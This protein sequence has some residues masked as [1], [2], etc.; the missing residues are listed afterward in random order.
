MKQKYRA[1]FWL[2][3]S[4]LGAM[5]SAP[6]WATTVINGSLFDLSYDETQ[7]FGG[8][9]FGLSGNVVSYTADFPLAAMG[10]MSVNDFG[11]GFDILPH[12][13]VALQSV[14]MNV[15][16]GYDNLYDSTILE[17]VGSLTVNGN[18]SNVFPFLFSSFTSGS[19]STSATVNAATTGNAI[20]FFSNG[21]SAF[22]SGFGDAS[23]SIDSIQ[24]NV[25][26]A[27]VPLPAA[28][29]LFSSGLIGLIGMA[30]RSRSAAPALIV[31]A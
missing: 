15:S 16:G 28:A 5:A 3:L 26:V 23:V 10:T 8:G 1:L 7:F 31:S 22:S 21:L 9:G 6:A 20:V 30:R 24:F 27:A 19:W 4:V 14:T 12:A 25:D 18:S 13:G 2:T 29:W 17:H 11:R